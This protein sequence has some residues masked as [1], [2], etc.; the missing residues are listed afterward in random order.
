ML[1]NYEDVIGKQY[2]GRDLYQKFNEFWSSTGRGEFKPLVVSKYLLN[3][4][5]ILFP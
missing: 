5:Y 2:R 3:I 4:P 1:E